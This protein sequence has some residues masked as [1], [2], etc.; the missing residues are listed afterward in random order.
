MTEQALYHTEVE[1]TDGLIGH[2]KTITSCDLDVVTSGP[3]SDQAGTNPE[4]LLAASF[5]TCLNATIE[6]EEKRRQLTHQS[7]VR[8]AIDMI[9]D[10]EGF[11]FIVHV[12]V[13]IP[14]VSAQEAEEILSIAER[15]CPVSKL[16]MG[17]D[18]VSISLVDSLN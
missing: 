1:N 10:T 13:K 12:Q 7:I 6:A 8:V 9:R 2:V 15:R 17:N 18:N 5:S 11:Q 16:L 14:H 4:Q 3:L